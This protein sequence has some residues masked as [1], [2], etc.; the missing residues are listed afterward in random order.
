MV[1]LLV[2]CVL[3]FSDKTSFCSINAIKYSEGGDIEVKSEVLESVNGKLKFSLAV[4][5][6]GKGIPEESLKKIFESFQNVSN[7]MQE[8]QNL[9]V[10][11]GLYFCKEI[12]ELFDGNLEIQS[13][14]NEGTTVTATVYMEN[15]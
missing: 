3:Y 6:S 2:Y 10:G 1:L 11:F 8:N 15:N 14:P 4:I 12:T 5:D 9:D 13:K 7:S